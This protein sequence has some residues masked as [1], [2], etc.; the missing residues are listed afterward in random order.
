MAIKKPSQAKPHSMLKE[1]LLW[2][3]GVKHYCCNAGIRQKEHSLWLMGKERLR[4]K[5][6]RASYN[7]KVVD[8]LPCSQ[9]HQLHWF[10]L[11][12]QSSP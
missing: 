10:M 2:E 11:V 1:N 7:H 6:F 5:Y 4:R 12:V 8:S 3:N 9:V